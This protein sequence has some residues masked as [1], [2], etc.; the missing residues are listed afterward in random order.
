M[1]VLRVVVLWHQHQPFYK[2]LVTGEYRLPWVRLH[3]LKDYYGMVKLLEEFPGVHQTF[4][5]VPSLIAQIQDYAAGSARDPFFH[6]A[7]LSA[8]DLSA[9]DRRFALQY[10][11]QANAEHLIGRYPRYAE[12]WDRFQSSG[13]APDR[14]EKYFQPQDFTDLQVL[15]QLAWFDEFFLREPEIANLVSKGRSFSLE[16]QSFVITRQRGLIDKVLPAHAEAAKLGRI[17]ISTS[18]LY[19]PILP[20]ICD[21][22]AGAAATPGLPLPLNRFR[23]PE[24][25]REQILRGLDLHEKVFGVRPRGLW[26]SEGSVSEEV[27]GIAASLGVQWIATDEGVLSRTLGMSFMRDGRGRLPDASAEKLYT[28]HRYENPQTRMHLLFRD[29]AI[30]DLIGF[31]YSGMPPQEAAAHLIRN[32][33]DSAQPILSQGNDVVMPIILDGENAWEYYPESGREFL[34]RFYD[35]LQR[36]P[37]IEALTVSEAIERQQNFNTLHSLTPG[38][39]IHANFNVWIGA[40]EDNK[41]WDYLYQARNFYAQASQHVSEE[42]RKLALEE[43]LIAEGSDWNWWYG[44][45]HHSANDRE[46]DELYRKH[47]SNVYQA[48]GATPPD[49]LAQPI[50]GGG[51]QPSFMPQTHYIH[52]RIDGQLVRYFEWM[53]AA[54]YTADRRSGAMHGRVFLLE[55]IYGGIDQKNVY[56]RIDFAEQIP[57]G[58]FEIVVNLESWADGSTRARRTLRLNVEV[59]AAKI[60]RWMVSDNGETL[61]MDDA[62]AVLAR[63]FEF[64]IPLATLYA[65][66]RESAADKSS[67]AATK[68]R[69]RFSVWQNRLPVDALPVEGWME[70]HLL[71]E[72]ELIALAH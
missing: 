62:A 46:F 48:L 56:G 6:V 25:A 50:T 69:I 49:Y 51:V 15:S 40:P 58:D 43:L 55:A 45:E 9:D 59:E 28:I 7:S 22:N 70:L 67:A 5:L 72:L 1:P 54:H 13:A 60:A 53:G 24:D 3:A 38:S 4:N 31:V 47:L 34:R 19:H 71:P 30:S 63:N 35:A 57:Q 18:P 68:L 14:A 41:S 32:I 10:L 36:D 12:L 20:L 27:L 8:N 66:P 26:P 16:D 44:P 61:P 2:D 17:E 33:K 52:P 64:K 23:H 21:T 65:E 29:H 11:F 37:S 39:W 42:Q